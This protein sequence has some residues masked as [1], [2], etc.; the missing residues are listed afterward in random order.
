MAKGRPSDQTGRPGKE[1][2]LTT[3]H[4]RPLYDVTVRRRRYNAHSRGI[5]YVAQELLVQES[6]STDVGRAVHWLE[7]ATWT[8]VLVAFFFATYI[9]V[10]WVTV[11]RSS[12]PSVVFSWEKNIPFVPW[13]IVPYWST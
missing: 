5:V 10:A 4:Q 11:Q 1:E 9:A 13:T 3:L 12:V 7:A 8:V 2:T 6:N